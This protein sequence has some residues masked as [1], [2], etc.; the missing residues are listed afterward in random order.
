[1]DKMTEKTFHELD[2]LF[3]LYGDPRTQNQVSAQINEMIKGFSTD[4]LRS[5]ILWQCQWIKD[6]LKL[7]DR[8]NSIC[9][10]IQWNKALPR[11]NVTKFM[12]EISQFRGTSVPL[13]KW[14]DLLVRGLE[15][16]EILLKEDI[17]DFYW[18]DRFDKYLSE[19]SERYNHL[20]AN[21]YPEL[22]NSSYS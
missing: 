2:H 7:L 14:N 13:E 4:D 20:A 16:L 8:V 6:P 22:Y 12:E 1:M 9:A 10:Q 18:D 5:Y 21:G 3:S 19:F 17:K 15:L 11:I